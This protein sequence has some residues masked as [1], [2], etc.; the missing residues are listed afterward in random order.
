MQRLVI[1]GIVFAAYIPSLDNFFEGDDFSWFFHT[2]KTIHHPLVF[3]QPVNNFFRL[4]ESLYFLATTV[5][6][7]LSPFPFFLILVLIHVL[8]T[9]LVSQLVYRVSSNP[10]AALVGALAWGLCYKH[11]EVVLRPYGI[12]DGTALLF[13]LIS[14]LLLLDGRILPSSLLMIPALF[15]KENALVF[16][17]LGMILLLHCSH[18]G[19]AGGFRRRLHSAV[20]KTVPLWI[21]AAAFFSLEYFGSHSTSYLSADVRLLSRFWESWIT[22]LGPDAT[23]VRM[24]CLG[25]MEYLFP[26][27]LSLFLL[28][29]FV[30][31]LKHL[32]PPLRTGLLWTSITAL[33][34][35]AVTF[36]SSRYHYIPFVGIALC[37]G[38]V[39]EFVFR[40]LRHRDAS[41]EDSR[42]FRTPVLLLSTLLL[43]SYFIVGIQTEERYT[44][45]LGDL[46]SRAVDSFR[47]K[48]MPVVFPGEGW[49][50]VF[51]K[52]GDLE[53]LKEMY[54]P[55]PW[56]RPET[57][58][59]I[60]CRPDGILGMADT[61]GFVSYCTYNR[62]RPFLFV[63][64]PFEV[65]A[66][67][68]DEGKVHT[69][70]HD[71][72]RGDFF[73]LGKGLAESMTGNI[74]EEDL[75]RILK[76]S[77]FDAGFLGSDRNPRKLRYFTHGT[78]KSRP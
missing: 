26:L 67:A 45:K 62:E 41:G 13:G 55:G 39:W 32:S 49:V 50:T 28:L 54:Q 17:L 35:M 74:S 61:R 31:L 59:W 30:L 2:L 77:Y 20:V 64:A 48:I 58:K 47:E 21:L 24:V 18:D 52:S 53:F 15:S 63:A 72:E 4:T 6:F 8:N 29:P 73:L 12:A 40:T 3:F 46:H 38:V 78:P 7:G 44:E 16:P 51:S 1:A 43:F 5:V 66:R 19:R 65:F 70:V 25:G 57:Y 10:T 36:Q 27:W 76:P 42:A 22:Y 11:S 37:F 71:P 33:P 9:V 69:V 34:T 68:R 56:Y 14:L 60:Y 23:W 75:F